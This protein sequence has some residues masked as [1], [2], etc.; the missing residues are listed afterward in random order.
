MKGIITICLVTATIIFNACSHKYYTNSNFDSLTA[1]HKNIAIV[2]VEVKLLGN[3]PK[4]MTEQDII[5]QESTE[6]NAFQQSL[7]NNILAYGNG[8]KHYTD[9]NVISL[10]K[11]NSI[12]NSNGITYTNIATKD[13]VTLCQLLGVDAVVRLS[14][15]KT[16]YMSDIAGFGADLLNDILFQ[17]VGVFIP[18]TT[19]GVPRAPEKTN[20]VKTVCNVQANN[21]TLWNNNYDVAANWNNPANEIIEGITKR[22]AK[23][24]PY[25]KKK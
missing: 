10:E 23:A 11:T 24:F 9:I 2:P 16:R 21:I 5:K 6:S 20:D 8:K 25:R 13:D 1:S 7:F 15:S 22:Y 4:K 12:L 18:G 14:I 19:T 17:K 3:K